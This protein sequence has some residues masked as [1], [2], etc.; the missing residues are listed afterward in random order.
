MEIV[1]PNYRI[2]VKEKSF[3][4]PLRIRKLFDGKQEVKVYPA[5]D[6]V[7]QWMSGL[8]ASEN[9]ETGEP[10][11]PFLNALGEYGLCQGSSVYS[12]A[13]ITPIT[14]ESELIHL[15]TLFAFDE[16]GKIVGISVV[17][18]NFERPEELYRQVTCTG[19]RGKGYGK[20]LDEAILAFAKEK[21]KR[22]IRLS[23]ANQTARKI[24]SKMGFVNNATVKNNEGII[25]M[26]KNVKGGRRKTR[27]N[28]N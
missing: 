28:K 21:G 22:V 2:D 26:R 13:I 12:H 25:T 1:N 17:G 15:A 8:N 19:V 16:E 5:G 20:M 14:G 18:E 6:P 27:R 4:I 7:N 10:A 11:H 23:P 9:W 24:H 3:K